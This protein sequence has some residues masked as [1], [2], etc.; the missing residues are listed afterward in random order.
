MEARRKWAESDS[1][2]ELEDQTDDVVSENIITSL[3][4]IESASKA[5]KAKKKKPKKEEPAEK[6]DPNLVTKLTNQPNKA[7]VK[8]DVRADGTTLSKK[9]K[10]EKEME[11]LNKLLGN[12]TIASGG[13]LPNSE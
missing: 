7:E 6:V 11:E 3:P 13:V 12:V 2:E 5:V 10:K 1:D 4:T 8:V 9:E